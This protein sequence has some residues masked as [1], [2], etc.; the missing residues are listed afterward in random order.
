MA[1]KIGSIL[2]NRYRIDSVLGQGGMGAV[3]KA[4]DVNLGVDVAVKEN[5][6]TTAEFARQFEREAKILA[7]LRHPNLPRVTDHFVIQGEG[8][9]LVMDF[10]TG[11]DL[12]HRLEGDGAVSEEEALPWFLEICDALAYLHRQKKPI[13]HRDVKPGNIKI[14]PDGRAFLV[15]F[16][17]AKVFEDEGLTTTGAKAM[18]PGFSPPEQYGTGRTDERTDIYSLGATMYAA[19][20]ASIP[21]DSIERAMQ[22]D[23]LTPVR[24]RSPIVSTEVARVIEKA[25]EVRP[26]ERFQSVIDMANALGKASGISLP[27]MVGIYPYLDHTIPGAGKTVAAQRATQALQP[28]SRRR[29]RLP[30]VMLL[31]T[32]AILIGIGA[33]YISVPDLGDRIAAFFAP[34]TAAP[35]APGTNSTNMAGTR[36]MTT[37]ELT[38]LQGSAT[39]DLSPVP[40]E[41]LTSEAT[42]DGTPSSTSIPVA[43]PSGGGFGQIA[44]VSDKTGKPQIFIIDSDGSNEKQLTSF[45]EGAC[46]PAW[47]P[48]GMK[49]VFTSPCSRNQ[50]EY[51]GSTLWEIVLDEDDHASDPE[52]L[53]IG[54]GGNYD[55]KVAPDG[56]R[57]AF[58][59]LRDG[60]AQLYVYDIVNGQLTN[61]F[62]TI[63]W[64]QQPTWSSAG[65]QLA[66]TSFHTDVSEIWIMPDYGGIEGERF[67]SSEGESS[68]S[69]A[70]WSSDG[71]W[72]LFERE[73]TDSPPHLVVAQFGDRGFTTHRICI[74]GAHAGFPMSEPRWS[75][76]A[77]WI[78]FE[79]WPDGVN[80]DIALITASCTS[81]TLLTT[82]PG[83]DFDPAWRPSP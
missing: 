7:R 18:T 13:I 75:P 4:F 12:R 23:K 58:T 54:P 15:D 51:L 42:V 72:I 36:S 67:S 5:L 20:T 63:A 83:W 40:S 73:K 52:T 3:Y 78:V 10:I 22:R 16:G 6:F 19:L 45:Q 9:Y 33:I 32:A 1:L 81:Y 46:Q 27:T 41:E 44:Y 71:V 61:L 48:D 62:E 64:Y 77:K 14:R 55:P 2:Q 26:H 21:E 28:I 49:L 30:M 38:T 59:S 34:A 47:Y 29:R 17:L 70:D 66:F 50:D 53:Q 35:T 79:T 60:R 69:H 80:H 43:T 82:D 68:D 65:T 24:K 39:A 8:Q 37:N 57:I 11:R 25:L 74:E 31:T 76:D 56:E